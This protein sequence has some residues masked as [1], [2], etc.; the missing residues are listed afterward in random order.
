LEGKFSSLI[1]AN[2]SFLISSFFS[3]AAFM[4]NW[5]LDELLAIGSEAF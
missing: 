1:S 4:L 2:S 3:K 5:E